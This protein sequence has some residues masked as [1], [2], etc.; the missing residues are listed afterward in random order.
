MGEKLAD[1]PRL[2]DP[3]DFIDLVK[4]KKNSFSRKTNLIGF[5]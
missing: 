5:L 3:E 4:I 1:I 2:L